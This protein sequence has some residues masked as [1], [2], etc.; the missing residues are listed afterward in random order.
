MFFMV[1]T[2][3]EGEPT[4]NAV[5]FFN[6]LETEAEQMENLKF[7]VFGLGNSTYEFYNAMGSKLNDKLELLGAQRFAPYGQGDDGLGTMDEDFLAWK[8]ECFDSLKNNVNLEEHELKYEPSFELFDELSLLSADESVSN[9]EPNKLYIGNVKEI[10]RGPFDHL[11]PF[12]ARVTKTK[13]LFTSKDRYCVHAEFDLSPSNLKYTT[14]DHLAIWPSNS[15]EDVEKFIACFNLGEKRNAVFSLKTLDSTVQLPFYTPITYEAVVRHHMEISGPISRQSLKSV[16]P[17]AP[18]EAAKKECLRLGSDK[19]EFAEKIHNKKLN[20]ADALLQISSGTPWDSVTFVFLIE[21][22]AS[23]QPRYYSISSSSLAEKST[24]H[25]TAVVEADITEEKVVTG[26]ATNLLKDIEV[27]QNASDDRR[28]A[29]YDLWGPKNKFE[30]FK[31]PVHVR[32]STFKLPSNPSTPIILVGPG[33]GVAPMRA[34]VRERVALLKASDS[35]KLGKAVLFYGC[36][37]RDEDYLYRE[38]WPDYARA[39][40][41]SFEMNVAFS[42]EGSKKVY[43]QDNILSKAK[44]LNELLE[45]G[46][47]IYVCGDAS[48]MARD[49]QNA[50]VQII[51][52]ERSISFERA[53]ELVRC[54]VSF[55][56]FEYA[57]RI[58]Q[59]F[60]CPI[61]P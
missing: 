39:L 53:S 54:L 50:F 24:I 57:S 43:V 5:E 35:I 45:A 28:Y 29:T 18:T 4:D 9:G 15:N 31:L 46:A 17:F 30:K 2:Y 48:K 42:R 25:V 49:V 61:S 51:S 47:F 20:L 40:G 41:D 16:A 33:T 8:E 32:R 10:T 12:L 14:G 44:N 56:L 23:L 7:T 38:E 58:A 59:S 37:R 22:I 3:G 34:F 1:A 11:H 26:V 6:W 13:E 60:Q 27:S 19:S 52:E 36:R 21:L 55:S